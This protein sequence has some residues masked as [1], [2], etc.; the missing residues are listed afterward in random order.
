[1]E[2]CK[3]QGALARAVNCLLASLQIYLASLFFV[4]VLILRGLAG[5]TGCIPLISRKLQA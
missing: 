4:M 1:M 2:D 5:D 3:A